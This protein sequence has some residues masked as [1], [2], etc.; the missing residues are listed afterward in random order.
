MATSL[1]VGGSIPLTAT[2]TLQRNSKAQSKLKQQNHE[3]EIF[4]LV[5]E[6]QHD[7]QCHRR[8]I[9]YERPSGFDTHR[10]CGVSDGSDSCWRLRKKKTTKHII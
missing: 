5:A 7:V 6:E 4:E 10:A 3:R 8:R 2:K 1:V 9:V